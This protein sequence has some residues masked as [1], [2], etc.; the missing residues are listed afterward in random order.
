MVRRSRAVRAPGPEPSGRAARASS[1]SRSRRAGATWLAESARCRRRVQPFSDG[2]PD[3]RSL[4]LAIADGPWGPVRIVAGP[5]GVVAVAMLSTAEAFAADLDRRRLGVGR[6]DRDAPPG[7]ARDL[8]DPGARRASRRSSRASRSPLDDVPIDLGDR[9][10]WDRLVLEGVRSI[11]RGEVASYGEVARRDRADRGGAG[12][13]RGGRAQPGRAARPVPPGDRRRRVA[14]RL[15]RGGVGRARGG[16][17]RQARRCSR[18]RASTS[19]DRAGVGCADT[20]RCELDGHARPRRA[21]RVRPRSRDRS[22]RTEAGRE[23]AERAR[24]RSVVGRG[25]RAPAATSPT[26]TTTTSRATAYKQRPGRS[27]AGRARSRRSAE[28]EAGRRG[29]PAHGRARSHLYRVRSHDR[30]RD[31][32]ARPGRQPARRP[33]TQRSATSRRPPRRTAGPRAR[34]S[35]RCPRQVRVVGRGREQRLD[36]ERRDPRVRRPDPRR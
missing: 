9:S 31:R 6:A 5:R 4:V 12:G 19:A 33:L 1:S 10:A 36:L 16:A 3:G 13:R 17:G 21:R 27:R 34:P 26:D 14:G 35:R 7:P 24:A 22:G 28:P 2:P 8:A 25:C 20:R 11:P 29:P 30:G 23:Q 15:R 18:S 32:H